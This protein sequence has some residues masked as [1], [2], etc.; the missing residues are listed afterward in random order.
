MAN[1]KDTVHPFEEWLPD[2]H[3]SQDAAHRPDVHC[4]TSSP[5]QYKTLMA[6]GQAT[7]KYLKLC[8]CSGL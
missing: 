8:V 3:L 6:V 7:V 2:D 1:R 5:S 4:N